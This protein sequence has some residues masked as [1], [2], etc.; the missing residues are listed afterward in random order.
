M[1]DLHVHS[2]NSD[3]YHTVKEILKMAEENN[4]NTISFCDHDVLGAYDELKNM[5]VKKYYSGRIITGIEF[6][7]VYD[8]K[9]FHILG[10]NLM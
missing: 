2:T 6:T 3:G 7:F 5:D 1:I 8:N 9:V 4:I 10:Y